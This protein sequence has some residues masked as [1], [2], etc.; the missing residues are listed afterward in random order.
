M[1]EAIEALYPGTKFGIGP[2]IENGYY[3]DIDLNGEPFG[4]DDLAVLSK[5]MLELAR[6][7]EVFHAAKFRKPKPSTISKEERSI[8]L[9]LIEG[10][11]DG[12]S[13]SISR[14][15]RRPLPWPAHFQYQFHQ[16]GEVVEC[17]RRI[18]ERQR[19]EQDADPRCMASPSLN[20]RSSTSTCTCSK[21]RR[22]ATIVRSGKSSS[23]LLS[24][25]RLVWVC[26]VASKGTILRERLEQFMR[27][28]Q[29]KAGYDPV[30]TPHIGGKEL[31]VTSG[32][33]E[34]WE[35]FVS[36][37]PHARRGERILLQ[38][39]ELPSPL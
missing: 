22:S 16:S 34:V 31:Y 23:F 18:L 29:V 27:K 10:L 3:Y 33:Y 11:E 38:A 28:A 20:R 21:K 7:S 5:K 37:Y 19:E 1:A 35:R 13:L 9:E 26:P 25:R 2:A 32:H 30:V 8:K 6:T 14:K 36:A 4:E 15:F 12:R 24:P 17:C 39:D